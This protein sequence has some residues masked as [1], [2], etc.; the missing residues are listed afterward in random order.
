MKHAIISFF[1]FEA[2]FSLMFIEANVDKQDSFYVTGHYFRS[3]ACLNQVIFAKTTHIVLM[4][5]SV[6][7]D[8]S[9]YK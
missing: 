4:K 6:F 2:L 8:S 3:I 7:Y 5:K 9:I 1:L